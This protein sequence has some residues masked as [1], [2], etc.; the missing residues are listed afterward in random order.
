MSLQ[1]LQINWAWWH[2]PLILALREAE[3]G[4]L[5]QILGPHGLNSEFKTKYIV[6]TLVSKT[7]TKTKQK[8]LQ[9][10]SH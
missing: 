6:D 4:E 9:I 3:V 8:K 10:M 5:L 1:K 2:T 7:Q